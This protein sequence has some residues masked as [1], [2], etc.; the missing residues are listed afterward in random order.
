MLTPLWNRGD[1]KRFYQRFGIEPAEVR[2]YNLLLRA[3]EEFVKLAREKGQYQDHT[4]NLRSSIGYVIVKDG[5]I[6]HQDYQTSN[7]GTDRATGKM[8][9]AQM[10]QEL[11]LIHNKGYVLIGTAAMKYAAAVE[12]LENK[13]VVTFAATEMEEFVRRMSRRLFDKLN[14]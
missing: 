14:K 13:D 3:G 2:I 12:A 4:G 1:V 11:A 5:K 8:R 6:I 9:A 10:A 7:R